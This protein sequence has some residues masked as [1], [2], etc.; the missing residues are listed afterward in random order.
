MANNDSAAY[1]KKVK[2]IADQIWKQLQQDLRDERDRRG[3]D[4][5]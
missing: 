4:R 3:K 1:Q 5:K 2:N